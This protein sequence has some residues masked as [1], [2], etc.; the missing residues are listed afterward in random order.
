MND[1]KKPKNDRKP[2]ERKP[3]PDDFSVAARDIDDRFA[4]RELQNPI[5]WPM[6]A[7]A[8]ALAVWGALTLYF[9]ARSN[10]LGSKAQQI[11]ATQVETPESSKGSE[12]SAEAATS[13]VA[14]SDEIATAKNF[15][16]EGAVLFATYCATCHQANGAGVRAAI[17]PLDAS[18]YVL[19]DPQVA[20]AIVLRGIAG[21]IEVG[22]T[23]YNGRM[24]TFHATL[25][26]AQIAR[27]LTH[28][29]SAWS[30]DAGAITADEVTQIRTSL[31]A[32]LATPWAGGIAIE[33][34]LGV[35][36]GITAFS[37]KN[38]QE[39]Q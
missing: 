30:N 33:R 20:I 38:A 32:D 4:P 23:I 26:D 8:L 5:P 31:G 13:A 18:R 37:S 27:I 22:D 2:G 6:L 28:V 36:A 25:S 12:A 39:A 9:D 34:G 16:A 21:P 3:F 15:A 1:D 35:T 17:P 29:R 11:A 19:A 14:G 10:E 24:P 7:I